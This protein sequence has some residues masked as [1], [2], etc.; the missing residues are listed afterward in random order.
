MIKIDK[1][2]INIFYYFMS[3]KLEDFSV[4][5]TNLR[6]SFNR[7]TRNPNYCIKYQVQNSS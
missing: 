1:I 2:N 3:L 5:Y 6:N 4:K 7:L